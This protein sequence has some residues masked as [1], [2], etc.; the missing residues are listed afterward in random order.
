VK[1]ENCDLLVDSLNILNGWKKYSRLLNVN[2]SVMLDR[3]KYI[4]LNH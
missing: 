1:G 2:V 4:R 3:E